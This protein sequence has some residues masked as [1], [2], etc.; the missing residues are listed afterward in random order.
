MA[1]VDINKGTAGTSGLGATSSNHDHASGGGSSFGDSALRG[2]SGIGGLFRGT[3]KRGVALIGGAALVV[4]VLML[5]LVLNTGD[6]VAKDPEDLSEA[7]AVATYGEDYGF[8]YEHATAALK[9]EYGTTE[10]EFADDAEEV[11]DYTDLSKGDVRASEMEVEYSSDR[12]EAKVTEVSFDNPRGIPVVMYVYL[13][14]AEDDG[15]ALCANGVRDADEGYD[16]Y[17]DLFGPVSG[18]DGC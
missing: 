14:R 1:P 13:K 7:V 5:A 2:L 10:D 4:L 12:P 9:Q 17:V 6:D 16:E 8:L 3:G 11:L 18:V 15:W